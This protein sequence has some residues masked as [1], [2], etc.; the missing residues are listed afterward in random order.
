MGQTDPVE[1][2]VR[3]VPLSPRQPATAVC[4]AVHFGGVEIFHNGQWGRICT[5]DLP[6]GREASQMFTLDAQVCTSGCSPCSSMSVDSSSP[7]HTNLVARVIHDRPHWLPTS[8][9]WLAVAVVILHHYVI[10]ATLARR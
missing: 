9:L 1:G 2:D 3:L 7:R 5:T 4:D 6:G 8:Q 10:T